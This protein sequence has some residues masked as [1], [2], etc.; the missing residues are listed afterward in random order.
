MYDRP[1]IEFHTEY[2]A[3]R[4]EKI[5]TVDGEHGTCALSLRN[6]DTGLDIRAFD[7]TGD[8]RISNAVHW[9]P[10]PPVGTIPTPEH[11]TPQ[12]V[13][14]ERIDRSIPDDNIGDG[15][16]GIPPLDAGSVAALRAENESLRAK[17]ADYET[18]E[19]RAWVL[20]DG[21]DF[22]DDPD[23]DGRD[24]GWPQ[25]VC[26]LVGTRDDAQAE[27]D[28]WNLERLAADGQLPATRVV[29]VADRD[30]QGDPLENGLPIVWGKVR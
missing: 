14:R 1:D 16:P 28:Q 2:E 24:G 29:H 3:D 10:V 27:A 30:G 26:V 18:G 11:G 17:L 25:P 23:L 9:L 19:A 12:A 13:E 5:V 8:V 21:Q 22:P 20:Y 6:T 4:D 15:A 7:P